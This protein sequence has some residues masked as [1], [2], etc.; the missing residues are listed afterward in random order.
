[1]NLQVFDS[2]KESGK[3]RPTWHHAAGG[4]GDGVGMPVMA[5]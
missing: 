4:L 5:T 2:E 3:F 1:M